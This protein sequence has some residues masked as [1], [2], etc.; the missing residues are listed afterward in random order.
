MLLI[1][2][3]KIKLIVIIIFICLSTL[4]NCE[5]TDGI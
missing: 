4:V 2:Q 5:S 3:G 1:L